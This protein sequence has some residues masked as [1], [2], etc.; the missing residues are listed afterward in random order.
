MAQLVKCL[1]GKKREPSSHPQHPVEVQ[2]HTSVILVLRRW[3]Q[4]DLRGLLDRHFSQTS[5][6]QV[7]WETSSQK[8]TLVPRK[9]HRLVQWSTL[10]R[11][12]SFSSRWWLTQNNRLSTETKTMLIPTR[13]TCYYILSLPRLWDHYTRRDG[14][15]LRVS[16]WMECFLDISGLLH[17][18]SLWWRQNAQT[19]VRE[20]PA[21]R[22]AHRPLL[23]KQQL[24]VDTAGRGKTSFL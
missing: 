16:G 9:W 4:E 24:V 10:I 8:M 15:F 7:R 20:R 21:G 6:L 22:W 5:K 19:Q 12:V 23:A 17:M 1:L 3:R 11:E 18:N 14:K 13:V 2:K